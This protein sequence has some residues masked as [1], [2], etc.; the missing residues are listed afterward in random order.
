MMEGVVAL[1]RSAWGILLLKL[2]GILGLYL[3]AT[4]VVGYAEHKVLAHMQARLGP[5]YAGRFHGWAQLIADGLKFLQKEDV[6]PRAADRWVFSLA[7]AMVVVPGIM[8]Y[9]VIPWGKG[10]AGFSSDVS[11]FYALAISA[12]SVVGVLMAGWA[13]ANKFSLIGALR[14]AAQLIAYELPLVLAAAAVA[15]QAGTASLE[16]IVE[17]QRVPFILAGQE[18]GF[19]IFLMASMA[20]LSRTPLDMPIADSEII[21]GAY[22]EYTGMRY[23]LFLLAEYAGMFGL[24]ALGAVL[25]LGGWRGPGFPGVLWTLVKAGALTFIMIWFRATYPRI[26]ED[27]LQKMAWAWLVPL[28]LAN[29]MGTAAFKLLF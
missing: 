18:L 4:L 29:L 8:L 24:A 2:I 19:F 5:M 21:A 6:I 10:L 13:S 14:S 3:V 7:P 26:R 12:V 17:A 16:G 22:T 15:L 28:S 27:Q 11:L 25:F 20:E 23:V 9:A 1:A